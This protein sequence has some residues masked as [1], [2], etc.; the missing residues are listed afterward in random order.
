LLVDVT[1]RELLL[2]EGVT[3][4][5]TITFA[6]GA[7]GDGE[8]QALVD[9]INASN[10]PYITATKSADGNKILAPLVTATP[11][12]GGVNPTVQNGDYTTALSK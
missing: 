4:R 7:T 8:P 3:L 11:L 5:Q 9:A 1:K 2:Y 12:A 10:S 6:K